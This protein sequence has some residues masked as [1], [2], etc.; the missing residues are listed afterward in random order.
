MAV[1]LGVSVGSLPVQ[2]VLPL[3]ELSVGF[4][5]QMWRLRPRR[6]SFAQVRRADLIIRLTGF[7]LHGKGVEL[8]G[9]NVQILTIKTQKHES[10]SEAGSFIAIVEALRSSEAEQVG[11]GKVCKIRVLTI[12]PTVQR[13]CE[14]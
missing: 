3:A 14:G 2:E 1:E 4:D 9:G 5:F 12:R 13:H 7:C 6:H 10:A 11:G 8:L